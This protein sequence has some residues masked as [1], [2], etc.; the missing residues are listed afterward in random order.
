MDY[1]KRLYLNN[2]SFKG[3]VDRCAKANNESVEKTMERLTVQ[4]VGR[5]YVERDADKGITRTVITAG[6]GGA[7]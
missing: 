3:Y 7:E 5:Y 2:D 6:C 1:F 4:N